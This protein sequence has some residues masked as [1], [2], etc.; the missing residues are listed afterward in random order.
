MNDTELFHTPLNTSVGTLKT[1]LD[2]AYEHYASSIR[3]GAVKSADFWDG[4]IHAY[5]NILKAGG[6]V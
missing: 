1:M 5:R 4:Q 3:D 2:N 6:H